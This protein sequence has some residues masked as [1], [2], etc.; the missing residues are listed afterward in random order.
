M[1]ELYNISGGNTTK[2]LAHSPF[3]TGGRKT[4]RIFGGLFP[5]SAPS[6][7][8]KPHMPVCRREL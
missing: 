2:I 1:C 4:E 5:I 3:S 6:F 8:Q 7:Q